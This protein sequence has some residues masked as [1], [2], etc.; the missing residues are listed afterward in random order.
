MN[1][2]IVPLAGFMIYLFF[3]PGCFV[4]VWL[5]RRMV[6]ASR[7]QRETVGVQVIRGRSGGMLKPAT[8]ALVAVVIMGCSA[9]MA[10]SIDPPGGLPVRRV[11]S[12][13]PAKKLSPYSVS[14]A[15][16]QGVVTG[17]AEGPSGGAA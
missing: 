15:R 16:E 6:E 11:T 3:C 2:W 8:S 12:P 7:R 1:E 10:G 4:W 5:D 14:S 9:Y 13:A 17:K